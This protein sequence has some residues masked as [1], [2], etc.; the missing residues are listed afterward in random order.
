[1]HQGDIKLDIY[2]Y[3]EDGDF[4]YSF[5]HQ[6]EGTFHYDGKSSSPG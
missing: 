2:S 4:Y 3:F 6:A 5:D 1:M